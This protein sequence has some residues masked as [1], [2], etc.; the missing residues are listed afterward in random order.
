MEMETNERNISSSLVALSSSLV[1]FLYKI[2]PGFNSVNILYV[3]SG[4]P[5]IKA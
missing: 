2:L 3:T 4:S 5:T 1:C